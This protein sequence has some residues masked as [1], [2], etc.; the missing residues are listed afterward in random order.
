MSDILRL[1]DLL[2]EFSDYNFVYSDG[3]LLC[4]LGSINLNFK[5]EHFGH[6]WIGEFDVVYPPQH[7]VKIKVPKPIAKLFS[8]CFKQI[9]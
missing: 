6:D 4:S 8:N 1:C 5:R 9:C 3:A 7:T 2:N